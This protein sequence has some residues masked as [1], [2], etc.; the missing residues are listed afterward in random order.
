MRAL[1]QIT[2]C[3]CLWCCLGNRLCVSMV[4]ADVLSHHAT[5]QSLL[6]HRA[7]DIL[8]QAR[9][10][11]LAGAFSRLHEDRDVVLRNLGFSHSESS[12]KFLAALSTQKSFLLGD[13]CELSTVNLMVLAYV[14]PPIA[15][16]SAENHAP[17]SFSIH[18]PDG[19]FMETFVV[20]AVKQQQILEAGSSGNVGIR[21]IR[22]LDA[23]FAIDVT[24]TSR[25]SL[26]SA[27]TGPIRMLYIRVDF[28]DMAGEPVSDATVRF[29]NDNQTSPFYKASSYGQVPSISVTVTPTFR[30][31][32]SKSYFA[33]L[34]S[35][36]E[37]LLSQAR[38]LAKN[39]GYDASSYDYYAVAFKPIWSWGGLGYV[40]APGQ[41]L[42]YYEFRVY[43]HETGHNFGSWHANAWK[44]NLAQS[45]L[46]YGAGESDEYMD[47]SDVMGANYK[48][49][50]DA[51]FNLV[52]RAAIGWTG[53][54]TSTTH[55]IDSAVSTR[56]VY[57]FLPFDQATVKTSKQGV[58]ISRAAAPVSASGTGNYYV[59][60]YRSVFGGADYPWVP[61]ALYLQ[62]SYSTYTDGKESMLVN[63]DPSR[64]DYSKAFLVGGQ[65]FV[66][67]PNK[68]YITP[69]VLERWGALVAV[70]TKP[71]NV[72]SVEQ[73]LVVRF[74]ALFSPIAV[75][76]FSVAKVF[77]NN[78]AG[79][80]FALSWAGTGSFYSRNF[81]VSFVK[82]ST[83]GNF[84]VSATISNLCASQKTANAT[85]RYVATTGLPVLS[86]YVASTTN[87]YLVSADRIESFAHSD[88][89]NSRLAFRVVSS[90]PLQD[91][92]LW[93]TRG[94][95]SALNSSNS[96]VAVPANSSLLPGG[97]SS[98]VAIGKSA[99]GTWV[100][101][102]LYTSILTSFNGQ[103]QTMDAS[104]VSCSFT[105][106][107]PGPNPN[108]DPNPDPNPNPTTTE[109]GLGISTISHVL[110]WVS[111]S[112]ALLC[113]Q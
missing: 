83:A 28:S 31:P 57:S 23:M 53:D 102:K 82:Q 63:M 96:S 30:M 37:L 104:K 106:V 87:E 98:F 11:D 67:V 10:G 65:T 61:S 66:D 64:T 9:A 111:G 69:I 16:M 5:Y 112:L 45:P 21:G 108:P 74:E 60:S 38:D 97:A 54:L 7:R 49:R 52:E 85:V 76:S 100:S 70:I 4:T 62:F 2:L 59:L 71:T 35:G 17:Y 109:N 91:L 36:T 24:L 72:T 58:R 3:L 41:W 43:A 20:D 42:Q 48:D 51:Y 39:N 44:V 34:S 25:V 22:L 68:I 103:E 50:T 90:A 88:L 89:M 101:S 77:A 55:V 26:S 110:Y 29:V 8:K 113:L 86:L 14:P 94:F 107:D 81:A 47:Y 32:N 12:S 33:S 19:T 93:S 40:G 75:G 79:T 80:A 84:T 92:Q 73:H 46:P 1:C 15:A 13:P 27:R 6:D 105:A 95:V 56:G 99:S 18:R 78:T